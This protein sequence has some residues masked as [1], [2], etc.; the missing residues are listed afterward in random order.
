MFSS[1][2]NSK[3]WWHALAKKHWYIRHLKAAVLSVF[4]VF[5]IAGGIF[6]IW[7]SR[8]QLPDL[9]AF[10]AIQVPQSTKIYDRTGK[11]LLYDIHEDVKRTV[12]PLTAI[13]T[14]IQNATIAVE[15]SDFYT[16]M[17]I[18]PLS[19]LRSAVVDLF[20]GSYDQGGS[21]I[22]Q[23]VIKNSLLTQDKTISRKIKEWVLAVKLARA[24]PK[25]DVLATYLN[26]T[27]YGG[28]IYGVEEA[29]KVFF[30]KDASDVDLAEAAYIAALPQAPSFYSPYGSNKAGLDSRQKFVLQ[31]MLDNKFITKDQYT[32]AIAETVNF[33]PKN[34][35]TLLAPHFSMYVRNYLESKYG[36]DTVIN[37]GLRVTTSLD[38][39]LQ[40][41]MEQVVANFSPQIKSQFGATN[42]AM[43]AID[44]TTGDILAM[45]GS[46][47]YYHTLNSG[48]FNAATAYRQPGSTFK[49]FVYAT[50][51][52]KGY[53]PDTVLFDTKTEFSTLCTVDGKPKDPYASSTA[54]YSPVEYDNNYEGPLSIRT[55]LAQSRNVPAVK[56][57]YLAGIADSIKTAQDMGITSLSDSNRYGLTLVLG[58]GE[59]SLLQLTS[60]YG[61]FAD[62]GVRNAYRSVM[63]V[64]D[65]SGNTL[66]KSSLSPVQ[67][68]PIQPVRQ[69][70]SILSDSS[71]GV[72]MSSITSV[73]SPLGRTVAIKTGT[74][75]DYRDV[76]AVGY[77]PNL[78]VGAWAGNNDDT[79]LNHNIASLVIT[80]VWGAFMSLALP[81]FPVQNFKVPDPVSP[82]LKPVLRG[83]WKGGTS[84]KI[85]SLSGKLATEY[86]P[87]SL[88]QEVV[89]NNVDS[90]LQWVDKS[91]PT[92]PIPLNPTD[93][94]YPYWQ[95]GVRDWYT[96][97]F[98]PANPGFKEV[99]TSTVI[100]AL[101][102]STTLIL[103]GMPTSYDD[104]H[105]PAN[106][107]QV[108][109]T[110]PAS[111]T[112]IAANQKTT[113]VFTESGKFPVQK[114]DLFINDRYIQSNIGTLNQFTFVP[115]DIEGVTINGTNTIKLVV[116]D[117]ILNQNSTSTDFIVNQ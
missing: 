80:P 72:R 13:S 48:N 60:A 41:K 102:A 50:L 91:N 11:V 32:K 85:D 71:T 40:Q 59:V 28:N 63:E 37:G 12:V 55:A 46:E 96:N 2:R 16:N 107:P 66:E 57:L 21:T 86:T 14:D 106:F 44:P 24:V 113:V 51:F 76:W 99:G 77:T 33:L 42:M 88:T 9:S 92:G 84:Y 47:N 103:P 117:N 115:K 53:T 1:Y 49:P 35:G 7:I 43:V 65:S 81:S 83:V 67:V 82:N 93:P 27:G 95:Y 116:Y 6:S 111:N 101:M 74:T 109:I 78:V 31:R 29:T 61:V 89:Q 64:D 17:G 39:D 73:T 104:I 68:M 38:Y 54:C 3:R 22:T 62:D 87:P 79:P 56:A 90:I 52:E 100:S 45:V 112:A 19:I 34:T 36:T 69:I 25:P 30:G 94:Q 4:S 97:V 23:Q 75:N 18:K 15:D 70:N 108:T 8:L 58:G 114:T 105:V 110:Y 5:F 10:N 26:E 98:L 20:T